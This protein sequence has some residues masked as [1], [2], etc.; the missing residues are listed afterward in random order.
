MHKEESVSQSFYN[1]RTIT[2]L[3]NKQNCQNIGHR[4]HH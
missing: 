1:A 4:H 2:L 3:T